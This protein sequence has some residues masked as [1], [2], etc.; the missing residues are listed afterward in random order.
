[1]H[2]VAILA[3]DGVVSFD[4]GIACEVFG[5]TPL[6][7]GEPAYGVHVCGEVGRVRTQAFHLDMPNGLDRIARADTVVVPGVDDP[8]RPVGPA[9]LAAIS[10][11]WANGARLV[12]ICTGAFVLAQTGLLDGRRATTHWL[13]AADFQRRFPRVK[14]DP[15]VLFVDEGRVVTSAGALAGMDMCLHLVARDHG[16]AVAAH[17]A[18][19]AV[20][21]LHRD[22]GQAQFIRHDLPPSRDGLAPLL[23][24]M[25]AHL[26]EPHDVAALAARANTSPRTFAR[27]FRQQTGTTPL[28]WLLTA[29]VRRAQEMLEAGGQTIDAVAAATGFEA[30]VTFRTRFQQVVGLS[31]SAYRRRFTNPSHKGA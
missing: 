10:A 30:P 14:L 5:R 22:G 24:W 3:L 12:S 20:A 31:P 1:M 27:R 9:V 28:Q 4:L 26:D 11:A 21:P 19:L 29:R 13:V 6:A 15:Q 25:L 17:A 18:R 8:G 16:Q 7:G 2:D 23:D